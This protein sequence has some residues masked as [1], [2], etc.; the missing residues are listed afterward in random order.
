MVLVCALPIVLIEEGFKAISRRR[1]KVQ[2]QKAKLQQPE[3]RSSA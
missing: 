3:Y 1:R 2:Q